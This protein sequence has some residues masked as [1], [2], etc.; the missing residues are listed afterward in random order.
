MAD[1]TKKQQQTQDEFGEVQ[2]LTNPNAPQTQAA[3]G[4]PATAPAAPVSASANPSEEFEQVNPLPGAAIA[5]VQNYPKAEIEPK[6]GQYYSEQIVSP[7]P[8]PAIQPP[9]MPAIHWYRR[10]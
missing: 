5:P 10:L 6:S 1:D 7:I 9:T 3:T 4:V 8:P 2:A